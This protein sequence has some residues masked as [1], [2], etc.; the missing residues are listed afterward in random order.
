MET[1]WL[2]V[3]LAAGLLSGGVRAQ[4][5]GG[6]GTMKDITERVLQDYDRN[7]NPTMAAGQE[8]P[9][10]PG[11]CPRVDVNMVD[12]QIY[13]TKIP[14]IN[15]KAGTYSLEGF[16]RLWW[17][18]TR[19]TFDDS[20]AGGCVEKLIFVDGPSK[21]WTPDFYFPPSVTQNI[22][23]KNDGQLMEVKPNG[24]VYWSQRLR[25][26]VNCVM[27]FRQM[28][29]DTQECDIVLGSYSQGRAEVNFQWKPG[30]IAMDKLDE[31][32]NNEWEIGDQEEGTVDIPGLTP[33]VKVKFT[34]T[35][36]PDPYVQ[37][38]VLSVI[39][40]AVSYFGC[41]IAKGAVPARVTLAIVTILVVSNTQAALRVQLPKI[42]YSVW[43][44]DFQMG[45]LIFNLMSFVL[46]VLVNF[47]SQ[48]KDSFVSIPCKRGVRCS[49]HRWQHLMVACICRTK[50]GN[51]TRRL[52]NGRVLRRERRTI[53]RHGEQ[54]V[55]PA[56][57][58]R[59]RLRP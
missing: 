12:A 16:F 11:E 6:Q 27:D 7:T 46:Y 53:A 26:T 50:P 44:L 20:D 8:A 24:E 25:V 3:L 31:Q 42:S 51:S 13:V 9:S 52:E 5:R 15:Q 2:H 59:R 4:T 30:R 48:Q 1:R 18:D 47:G 43:L 34:L 54:P 21:L 23:A 38:M 32:I 22:G 14:E 40:V 41:W 49:C 37:S 45:C 55:H 10:P 39:F 35:R 36:I 17:N 57:R 19:L 28:P 33:K 29:W 56:P 58:V